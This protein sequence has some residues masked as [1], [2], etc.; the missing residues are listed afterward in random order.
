LA[1]VQKGR[2]FPSRD[3]THAIAGGRIYTGNQAKALGLVDTLGGLNL[4]IA[5]AAQSANITDYSIVEFPKYKSA[6]DKLLEGF[7]AE[8]ETQIQAEIQQ[9]IQGSVL[10]QEWLN[11]RRWLALLQD[12]HNTYMLWPFELN[13]N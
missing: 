10:P 9:A 12:P 7:G 4:A 8:S 6:V 13:V 2:N 5:L 3:S 11:L 1:V